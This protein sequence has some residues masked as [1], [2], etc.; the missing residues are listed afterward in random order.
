MSQ[1][2]WERE[3]HSQLQRAIH[4]VRANADASPLLSKTGTLNEEEAE[5]FLVILERGVPY[6][7]L[8]VCDNDCSRLQ[9]LLATQSNELAIDRNS[10]S[11]P[12]L[13]FT[14]R[15]T[16]EYRIRVVMERCR[17]NPCWY[18]VGVVRSGRSTPKPT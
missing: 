9:L 12:V 7:I 13:Q 10:E 17:M 4:A 16:M 5:T 8:G 1:N 18:G 14:P 6:S 2:R 15:A 11:F 3:V